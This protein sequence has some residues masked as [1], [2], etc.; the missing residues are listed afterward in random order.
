M[1]TYTQNA[2]CTNGFQ[3]LEGALTQAPILAYPDL[4]Y[5]A[6]PFVVQMDGS[7]EELGAVLEQ[8]DHVIAYARPNATIALFRGSGQQSSAQN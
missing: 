4:H 1:P 5:N 6:A 2:A 8:G 3:S 7:A